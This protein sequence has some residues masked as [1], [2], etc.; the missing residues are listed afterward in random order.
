MPTVNELATYYALKDKPILVQHYLNLK[1]QL[2]QM[3]EWFTNYTG[4]FSNS[5]WTNAA[6]DSA[7]RK[8]YNDMFDL[9]ESVLNLFRITK[10][11]VDKL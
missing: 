2:V 5:V 8:P 4:S 7:I 3:D 6:Y 1:E 9:Y 11:Y 10:Y